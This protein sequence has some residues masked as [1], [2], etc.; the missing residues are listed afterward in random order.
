MPP[1][2][3]Q[4]APSFRQHGIANDQRQPCTQ[5]VARCCRREEAHKMPTPGGSVA[6]KSHTMPTL[7]VRTLHTWAR[8]VFA[9]GSLSKRSSNLHKRKS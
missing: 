7:R 4:V 9:I 8:P 2:G 6:D 5:A 1:L 3:V